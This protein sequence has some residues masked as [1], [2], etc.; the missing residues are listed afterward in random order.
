MRKL[1]ILL[2]GLG[3]VAASACAPQQQESGVTTTAHAA[4]EEV[5]TQRGE[6]L[7][8]IMG[9]DDCH[10]PFV[11]GERGPEPDMTRRF[12]GHPEGM[13]LPPPPA[14]PEPWVWI[15]TATN[16]AYHGPWGI[17]YAINLT[18]DPTGMGEWNEETFVQAIKTG[19]HLGT[20]R[21]IMP[22]M[23]WIA[24]QHATEADLR[25]I[26]AYL[27]T[28]PPQSNRVPEYQPPAGGAPPAN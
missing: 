5:S 13:Q 22:P 6:Y 4:G 8:K 24:Y 25:S 10:T 16:T 18:P 28:V 26:F 23:P 12:A 2:V 21:P 15:G 7:V 20:G 1:A 14:L 17:S 19:R 9:C 27:R 11:M 3:V